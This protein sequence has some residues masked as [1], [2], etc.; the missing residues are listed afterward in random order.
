MKELGTTGN[1]IVGVFVVIVIAL[2]T[3]FYGL[4]PEIR[5]LITAATF[6]FGI[7]AGFVIASRLNR[8]SRYRDF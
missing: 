7:F 3:P 1:T 6:L 4:T 8:Y 5:N 2:Y